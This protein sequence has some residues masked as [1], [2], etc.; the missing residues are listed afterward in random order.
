[1]RFTGI[2]ILIMGM[3]AFASHAR[4]Y[5]S[6]VADIK[7]A[8]DR[9]EHYLEKN[10][11]LVI[12]GNAPLDKAKIVFL[13]EIHDDPESLKTQ[14]MLIA[15]E[16]RKNRSFMVLDES[17]ASLKKSMW[18]VFSQKTMEIIAAHEQRR[19]G[20]QYSPQNFERSLQAIA[21][22]MS[23]QDEE[24]L[25]FMSSTGLWSLPDFFTITQ[26]FYG[27]D[28]GNA[29]TLT[30]RNVQMV[31]SLKKALAKNDR[32][33]VM[34][35]ARHV[36]ELEFM[37]SQ[38]L[39]CKNS[40]YKSQEQF[41]TD[42]TRRFGARPEITNGIGATAPIDDFLKSTTY[43]VVFDKSFYRELDQIV[44]QYKSNLGPNGCLTLDR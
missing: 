19:N 9:S 34:A 44:S 16:Q 42:I 18:D 33:L 41:F 14:I 3:A 27:W 40:R 37:T 38:R 36:P 26:P 8:I 30:E 43:A 11:S 4:P 13:P 10:N 39:L 12:M 31:S 7:S 15:R 17:L 6:L 5:S 25:K 35:G 24:G 29:G 21:T 1:M 22:K 2:I 20:Q 32:I 28:T 23:S